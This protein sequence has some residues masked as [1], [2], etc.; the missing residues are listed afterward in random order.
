MGC[1]PLAG[2]LAQDC[3]ITLRITHDAIAAPGQAAPTTLLVVA[4]AAITAGMCDDAAVRAAAIAYP[5]FPNDSTVDQW[6]TTEQFDGYVALG[7]HVAA[8]A[9]ERI[10]QLG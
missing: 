1:E 2:K 10:A 3:V 5:D 6:L 4:M 8:R 7:R 9:R